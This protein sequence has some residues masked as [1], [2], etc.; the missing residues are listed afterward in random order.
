VWQAPSFHG[1]VLRSAAAAFGAVLI[2]VFFAAI[3]TSSM[4]DWYY[5]LPRVFGLFS[6][7]V[8]LSDE[9]SAIHPRGGWSASSRRAVAQVWIFHRGCCELLTFAALAVLL[10]IGLVALG[11]AVSTDKTLPGALESLGG[12]GIAF[13]VLG[14]VG[15]RLRYGLNFMQSCPVGLGMWVE[16]VDEFGHRAS[17]LVIDVSIDPGV[18]L[19]RYEPLDDPVRLFVP[20]RYSH[21]LSEQPRPAAVDSEWCREQMLVHF[22]RDPSPP[23]GPPSRRLAGSLRRWLGDAPPD[24]GPTAISDP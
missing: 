11:N 23:A 3:L 7:P 2:T 24:T 9:E 19:V 12:S 5:I 21:H 4:V 15:P 14:Y 1:L 8:W 18:K 20:L 10:A 6:A 17:G 16:G 13:G 22:D